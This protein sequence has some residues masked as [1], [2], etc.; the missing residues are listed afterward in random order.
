MLYYR[1]KPEADQKPMFLRK[2]RNGERW[3]VYIKGELFTPSE[4]LRMGLEKSYLTPVEVCQ[5]KTQKVFGARMPT[6]DASITPVNRSVEKKENRNAD[7]ESIARF[8]V[9]ARPDRPHERGSCVIYRDTYQRN[10]PHRPRR[11]A[12]EA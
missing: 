4:V 10:A 7:I 11:N 3:S 5:K 1:V 8:V 6:T 9:T 12:S 2:T